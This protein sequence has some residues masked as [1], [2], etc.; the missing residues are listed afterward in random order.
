MGTRKEG[1]AS[2]G[3]MQMFHSEAGHGVGEDGW[4]GTRKDGRASEG[5]I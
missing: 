4:W 1:R 3:G 2:E 5:G